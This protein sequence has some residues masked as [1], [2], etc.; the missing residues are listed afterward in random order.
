MVTYHYLRHQ[1]LTVLPSFR[2]V[3]LSSLVKFRYV[4]VL[5]IAAFLLYIFWARVLTDLPFA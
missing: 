1:M 2:I 5:S 4:T 3:M